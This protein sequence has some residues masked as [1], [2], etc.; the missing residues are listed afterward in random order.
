MFIHDHGLSIQAVD[1]ATSLTLS[2]LPVPKVMVWRLV[3]GG[4]NTHMMAA[5][6]Q[7]C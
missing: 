1:S 6:A 4:P 5:A 3:K 7:T 2:C